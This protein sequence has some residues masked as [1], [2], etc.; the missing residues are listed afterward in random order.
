M[1][2]FITVFFAFFLMCSYA[3]AEVVRQ[4]NVATYIQFNIWKNDG[5]LLSSAAGLDS[6]ID[7]WA[8]GSAPDGF[9]DCSNEA[10]EIGSTGQY[11]LSLT[12]SEMNA[13]YIVIQIKSS[14]SGAVTRTVKI[15]TM[16]GDHLLLATTDDGGVI[17][18]TSGKIDEV[19]TLTGHTAQTGDSYAIVNNGTY[20]N[21][22]LKTLIDAV[23]TVTEIQAEMEEN[24][25]S[26]LDTIADKLPTN[27]IMG[28]SDQ[29]DHDGDFITTAEVN[30]EV[31][32][33]VENDNKLNYLIADASTLA[34]DVN[35]ASIIGQ[36]LDSGT[37]WSFDRATDALEEISGLAGGTDWDSNE[38]DEIKAVLGVTGTGTPD[39]TPTAGAL[40]EI[41]GATFATGT[42][43][44][45]A[46]RNRGDAAWI[47]ATGFSTHSDSD[48][49]T[50]MQAVADDFKATGFSTHSAAD[51]WSV[52][53]RALTDKAGFSLSAA[54]IDSIWDEVITGHSTADSFGKVFDD[55]IDGLRTYGDSG[56]ATAVGFSTH[57]ASDVATL[58][59]V[60]PGNKLAT[61]ASGYVTALLANGSH[62][63]AA[64]TLTL[65]SATISNGEGVGLSIT[66]TTD[67]LYVEGTAGS[68]I[69]ALSSGS[70]GSGLELTGNGSGH[71]VSAIAGATGIGAKFLGGATSG[72][73]MYIEGPTDG[74]GIYIKGVGT[75]ENGMYIEGYAGLYS[76]STAVN[77]VGILG[78]GAGT[79][80]AGIYGRC[81]D[82]V[83]IEGYS[84]HVDGY[85][86]RA[87]NVKGIGLGATSGQ[88][89]GMH[90]GGVTVGLDIDASAGIGVDIDAAGGDGMTVTSSDDD[91]LVI[92]GTGDGKRDVIADIYGVIN[93]NSD[94]DDE[95]QSECND[96]LI[97]IH[98]D[99]LLAQD[100]DPSSKP[101]TATALL[102]E[103]IEN[104]SGVSRFTENALEQAPSG[105][106]ATAQDVW[107][108]NISAMAGAG[109][110]GTYLKNL[111]DNQGNWLTATGFSTHSAADVWSVATRQLTGSQTFNL[112]GDITGSLSGAVGSVTGA[113]GSVTAEVTVGTNN[114]K[115]GYTLSVAGLADYFDTDSGTDYDSAVAG[116][117]VKEIVDNIE[118][119]G[120][121]G[122]WETTEKEQIRDAL[123][124]TG[125]TTASTGGVLQRIDKNTKMIR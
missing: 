27:Y 121:S 4:K 96:A 86:I 14:T 113:V 98:L 62:G 122:D 118:G 61:D 39:N 114:D 19:A 32:D 63:G 82:G 75:G 115:T 111:Y 77:G 85:G 24:G 97:A 26:L 13:D 67:G 6:E 54:G 31:V 11:Y 30:A 44:L 65:K 107:E 102:N 106:G 119:G 42:D 66:G 18:V 108:Y 50:A 95:M 25:S 47:T 91:G 35:L 123:G 80:G 70:N 110:A 60:T 73:G 34:D 36:M 125:D 16:V 2:R 52:A 83:G 101:G 46:L 92:I 68:G 120:G 94:W 8:D 74:E 81:D 116:S 3:H 1:K 88:G 33:V 71:G 69:H 41:Q 7:A 103:L 72:D 51:V 84:D 57:S 112:T 90:I 49:V 117:V 79:N 12:Q 89:V 38:K 104:D 124:V 100:Y 28:S 23:P 59:L 99:H 78:V 40:Y 105:S 17:N 15:R 109:Y 37:A 56:W 29:A 43:S 9:V 58:L 21:S 87:R 64:A 5:T 10:T 76:K 22:A 45:E 55:Q 20:G 93:W 53:T 48:V